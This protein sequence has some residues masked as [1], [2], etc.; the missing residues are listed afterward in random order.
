MFGRDS[1][2]EIKLRERLVKKKNKL[3]SFRFKCNNY[4]KTKRL[5]QKKYPE[6]V[7][8][9]ETRK[10]GRLNSMRL[11]REARSNFFS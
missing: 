3:N 4:H 6:I 8:E 2:D 9:I 10:K 11:S 7:H 1:F 5:V